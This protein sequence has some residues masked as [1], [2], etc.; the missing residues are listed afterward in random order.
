VHMSS[1][2]TQQLTAA[3]AG[4]Q[5]PVCGSMASAWLGEPEACC[6]PNGSLCT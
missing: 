2:C 1:P 5:A 3:A 4:M 6:V